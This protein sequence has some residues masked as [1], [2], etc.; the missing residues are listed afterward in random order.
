MMSWKINGEI[1]EIVKDFIFW[2]VL[3][4]QMVTAP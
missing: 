1:V 3:Q 2:G 4:N